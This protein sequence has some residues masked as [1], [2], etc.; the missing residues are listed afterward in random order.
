MLFCLQ[1]LLSV[2]F[3]ECGWIWEILCS[4]ITVNPILQQERELVVKNMVLIWVCDYE[5]GIQSFN[6]RKLGII[7][8]NGKVTLRIK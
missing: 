5:Q 4:L 8:L 7:I 2:E 1:S 6:F 3:Y